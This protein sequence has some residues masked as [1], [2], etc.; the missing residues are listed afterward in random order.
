MNRSK[1][2]RIHYWEGTLPRLFAH[3]GLALEHPENTLEAFQHAL[4][5]GAEYLETDIQVSADGVA[6]I[7]HDPDLKRVVGI[8]EQIHKLNWEELSELRFGAGGERLLNIEELLDLL[9]EARFNI[10]IKSLGAAADVARAVTRSK[11]QHRVLIT[12]FSR[13]RR[14]ATLKILRAHGYQGHIASSGAASEA[15]WAMVLAILGVTKPMRGIF[16]NLDALQLPLRALGVPLDTVRMIRN[17]HA[18]GLEVHFWTINDQEQM[19]ELFARGADGIVTDRIDLAAEVK[20][21]F[22]N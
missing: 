18:L 11:A 6:V 8:S 20:A 9:P 3:R 19:R 2:R 5:C 14:R 21:E 1:R 22:A 10:D 7:A 15:L 16:R 4:A 12:S 17:F 13:R